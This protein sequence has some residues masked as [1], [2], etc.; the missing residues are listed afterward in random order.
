M[1]THVRTGAARD[2]GAVKLRWRVDDGALPDLAVSAS[3]DVVTVKGDRCPKGHPH[4]VGRSSSS[5]ATRVD[6][7]PLRRTSA[8]SSIC[9]R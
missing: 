7:G 9:A 6:G 1:T 8:H 2:T 4:R 3:G 5:S